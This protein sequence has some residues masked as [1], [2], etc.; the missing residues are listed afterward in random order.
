M[1]PAQLRNIHWK[2]KFFEGKSRRI[3]EFEKPAYNNGE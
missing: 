3:F 2:G 1:N